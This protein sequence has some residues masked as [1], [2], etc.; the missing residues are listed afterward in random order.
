MLPIELKIF[1]TTEEASQSA[2]SSIVMALEEKP[3]LALCLATG[4]SPTRAYELFTASV[5]KSALGVGQLRLLKLDEWGGLAS[6]DPATCEVYLQRY[7]VAPL[8]LR[9]E[10]LVGFQSDAEDLDGECLRIERH[11]LDADQIDVC[12]LGLGVNGHIGF[13]EP[14]AELFSRAHI[15]TLS[16]ASL[17]HSMLRET[18]VQTSV[19]L[20]LGMA[21]ILASRYLIETSDFQL[22]VVVVES[23][24][25]DALELLFVPRLGHKSIDLPL[26]DGVNHSVGVGVPRHQNSRAIG[27]IGHDELK[28]LNPA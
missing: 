9:R 12:V 25:Q 3:D 15:A 20:T 7:L 2:A 8:G 22:Q 5:E 24:T 4:N 28:K 13:N 19:G 10:Q 1:R 17:G 14:A 6:D 27:V 16:D 18:S 11:L 26:V 23:L 21:E